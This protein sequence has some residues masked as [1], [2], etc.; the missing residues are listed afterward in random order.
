MSACVCRF[1]SEVED[2]DTRF[3]T[4]NSMHV[5]PSSVLEFELV[6]GCRHS[7]S[8]SV[9]EPVRLEYSTD[10]GMTWS[11]V[12]DGCWPPSACTHYHPASVYQMDEFARWT[13]VTIVLP[14]LTW[15]VTQRPI[16]GCAVAPALC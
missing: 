12:L 3:V 9:D 10:H 11:L 4:T 7:G 6:T 2:G 13:R 5:G 16:T 1:N 14:L 8:R 15:C